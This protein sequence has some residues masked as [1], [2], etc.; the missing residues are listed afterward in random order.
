MCFGRLLERALMCVFWAFVL[1]CSVLFCP[2][3]LL[4]LFVFSFFIFIVKFLFRH[5]S[6]CINDLWCQIQ[7]NRVRLTDNN[8]LMSF[9]M[10]LNCQYEQ[11]RYKTTKQS[12]S[13]PTDMQVYKHTNTH[14]K[15]W[16]TKVNV[17]WYVMVCVYMVSWNKFK[18]MHRVMSD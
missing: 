4:S 11:D 18:T 2:V 10:S 17:K 13:Q 8:Y 9:C 3:L 12:T 16:C 5:F 1:S 6:G 15:N 7:V 14:N